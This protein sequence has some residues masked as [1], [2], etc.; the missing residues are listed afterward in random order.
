MSRISASSDVFRAVADPTRRALLDRLLQADLTVR[1]LARPF[2]MSQ[3]AISQH[4]RILRQAG[5]V[6]VRRLG[7]HRLYR[8]DPRPVEQVYHWAARYLQVRDPSGHMWTLASLPGSAIVPSPP[9]TVRSAR[10]ASIVSRFNKEK[11]HGHQRR[12]TK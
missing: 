11:R 7:K 2:R 12:E 9:P 4:L 1:V 10:A 6:R 3:P 5:L 8:V